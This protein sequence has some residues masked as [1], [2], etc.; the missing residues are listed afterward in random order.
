MK[1]LIKKPRQKY[2]GRFMIFGL[3]FFTIIG[4]IMKW[5]GKTTVSYLWILSPIWIPLGIIA[6]CSIFGIIF[7]LT[8]VLRKGH[9]KKK[10]KS[11]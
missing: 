2:D 9:G 3:V 5:T 11:R 6:V 10:I 4:L 8:Q 7:I 1:Q